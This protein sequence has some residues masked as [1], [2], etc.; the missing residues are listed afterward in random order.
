[1]IGV[2][3]DDGECVGSPQLIAQ[4]EPAPGDQWNGEGHPDAIPPGQAQVKS[5][6]RRAKT[7]CQNRE[8][9]GH[10]AP[11]LRVMETWT[12]DRAKTSQAAGEEAPVETGTDTVARDDELTGNA[13]QRV[14]WACQTRWQQRR[15]I[16]DTRLRGKTG[17]SCMDVDD[18]QE[19]QTH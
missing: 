8:E 4:K 2:C 7:E 16:E 5:K 3:T 11:N 19:R 15:N 1:M 18:S 9:W 17:M 13:A 12:E 10:H 6:G 14:Q